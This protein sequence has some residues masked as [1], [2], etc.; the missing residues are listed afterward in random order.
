MAESTFQTAAF[1]GDAW[2][3]RERSHREDIGKL[4]AACAV[5]NEWADLQRLK[6]SWLVGRLQPL[7]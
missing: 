6:Q 3:P 5:D 7:W 4:W 2:Q 1:G